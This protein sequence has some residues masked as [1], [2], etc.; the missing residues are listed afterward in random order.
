MIRTQAFPCHLLRTEAEHAEPG[1][2]PGLHRN[3]GLALPG[4]P[5]YRP[6]VEP[7]RSGEIWRLPLCDA[8]AHA[9]A[10]R[11]TAGVLQGVQDR[12]GQPGQ[13]GA[14]P[15]PAETLPHD[16]LEETGIRLRDGKLL[17][18]R[19]RGLEP[20]A[21]S[22]ANLLALP[23]VAFLEMRLVYNRAAR[24]DQWHAVIEEVCC[25]RSRQ[26]PAWPG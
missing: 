21:V 7:G 8:S 1:V 5:A 19:A 11:C 13:W 4:V 16:D 26:E 10:G 6:L 20:I 12:Q 14:L 9:L 2:G 15:A 3:L 22:A 23:A 25:P 24:R 18:A 17:L